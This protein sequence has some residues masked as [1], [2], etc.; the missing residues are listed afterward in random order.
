MSEDEFTKLFRYMQQEFADLHSQLDKKADASR[1]DAV[2]NLLDIVIKNQET[3]QQ[4]RLSA[5][6]QL[7]KH[8][9]WIRCAAVT[10]KIPY[11]PL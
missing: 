7:D 6:H 3:E 8:D 4:K 9:K 5:N 1:V 11:S 2:Y 10:V